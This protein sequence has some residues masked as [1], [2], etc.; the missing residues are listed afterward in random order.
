MPESIYSS[1]TLE[2]LQLESNFDTNVPPDGTCFP[3]VK[4]LSL[5]LQYL[6]SNLMEKLFCRCP[7]LEEL[8]ITVE[9]NDSGNATNIV[10]S[11]STLK[12]LALRV[13]IK[14]EL[15]THVEHIVAITAPKIECMYIAADIFRSYVM[16]ALHS[17]KEVLLDIFYRKWSE[18]D[19]NRPIQLLARVSRIEFMMINGGIVHVSTIYSAYNF[20]FFPVCSFCLQMASK[21]NLL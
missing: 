13:A 18:V 21:V 3:S 20:A 6:E 9:L 4:K 15:F 5:H 7:S 12:R 8:S 10:I 19:P 2:V 1:S 17:L 11:F 14:A 16:H